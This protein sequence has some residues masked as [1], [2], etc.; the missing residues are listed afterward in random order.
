MFHIQPAHALPA[1]RRQMGAATQHL[2]DVFGQRPDVGPFA[3]GDAKYHAR[4]LATDQVECVNR[5]RPRRTLQFDAG[6]CVGIQGLAVALERGIHR[7]NLVDFTGETGHCR[8]DLRVAT[9][10]RSLGRHFALDIT[11]GGGQAQPHGRKIGLVGVEQALRELGGLAQSDRKQAGRE[12]VKGTGVPCLFR[13]EETLDIAQAGVGRQ[14]CR[15]VE[16][17]YAIQL[18]AWRAARLIQSSLARTAFASSIR[19]E[20]AT[21]RSRL[22]SNL[23]C[24][25]GIW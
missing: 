25:S 16:Q 24:S 10:H 21:P 2:P 23:K 8:A 14:A 13:H 20:S 5:H 3:A 11:G 18:S 9:I 7:R 4:V 12:R 17:Q 19:C 6:T 15:F 22:S 1:Q